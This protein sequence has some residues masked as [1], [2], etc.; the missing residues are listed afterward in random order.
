MPAPQR[1]RPVSVI[2]QLLADPHRFQFFQAVRMLERWFVRHR[3]ADPR[4]AVDKHLRFRNSLSLS[5]P[6]SEIAAL[7]PVYGPAP[8]GE[9]GV[10]S[11]EDAEA[12]MARL[13]GVEITPAF[14]GLLGTGGALPLHYS[15]TVARRE[16]YHRDTAARA[17]FDLFTNRAAALFYQAWK[18]HRLPLHYEADR[19][20][21]FLPL[22]LSFAGMGQGP[23]REQL[24]ADTGGAAREEG[25][26]E[27]SLAYFAGVLHQRPASAKVMERVLADYFGVSVAVTSFVGRW[28]KLPREARTSLGLAN[29]GLGVS[30]VAGEKVWQRDLRLRIALGPLSGRA[31]DD[32]LPGG[33]GARALR[34][35][36]SL[37]TGVVFEYEVRLVLRREEAQG[38][39][40][41][42]DRRN[43]RLGWDSWLQSRPPEQDRADAGYEILAL[44]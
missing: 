26:S 22:M 44:N 43:G 39:A 18:K 40:L 11:I 17:F 33:R 31:F 12:L 42:A 35:L 29:A 2:D 34:Q 27:V 32:L 24:H 30:T 15:E 9:P 6:A 23:L 8:D 3:D 28:Y 19:K 16:M 10:V 7:V 38:M 36:V 25:L 14:I 41:S 21:R 20:N 4:E 37:M 1:R 5:F 13:Q